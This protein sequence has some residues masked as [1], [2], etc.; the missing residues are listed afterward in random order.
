MSTTG[1]ISFG[2][3]FVAGR[4]RVPKP[5]TGKIAFLIFMNPTDFH[6]RVTVLALQNIRVHKDWVKKSNQ[7][8]V[9]VRY[10]DF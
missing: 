4:N 7:G 3:A 9:N 1:S 8:S 5:P 6:H 10:Y 2:I